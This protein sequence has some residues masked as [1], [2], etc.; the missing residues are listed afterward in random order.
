MRAKKVNDIE[1]LLSKLNKEHL[2][3]FIRRE[4]ANNRQLKQRFLALGV[5]VVFTPKYTDYQ[6]RV[7]DI[8][9][10]FAGRRGYVSYRDTF[11]L[12]RAVSKIIDEAEEA[13][14]NHRWEV[15][16]AVL[17]GV[18]AASEDIISCGDDSA[19]ELGCIVEDCFSEWLELCREELLPAK[20]KNDIF[21]LSISYFEK[22]HLKDYDWW[23]AWIEMAILLADTPQKQERIVN[24]LDIIINTHS[25]DWNVEYNAQTAQRYK[26]EVM[27]RSG[28]PEE[29]LRF[30]YDNVNNPDFRQKLLQLSWDKGDYEEVLRLAEEGV[31]HDSQFIGL[32]ND[33][34]KWE[35]KTYRHKND[36]ANILKL[37]Q[38]F[39][40]VRGG[41][42]EH[43]YSM[44]AMYALMKSNIP[45]ENWRNFVDSLIKEA[46]EKGIEVEEL[47]IYTQEKMWD[48]YMDFLRQRP[49]T[50]RLDDAPQEVWTLYKDELI[51][52]YAS[53]VKYYFQQ[54]SGRNAYCNGVALLRRLIEYGG[55]EEVDVIVDELKAL[56]PR[57]P[58]LLD[59][60]SKL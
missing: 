5:E 6:S 9:E 60:L 31:K 54:A 42:G 59:E 20:V 21:E 47:F 39:F 49:S 30:M 44:E 22:G 25:D 55:K 37:A 16:I 10:D 28:T 40:F 38:Y 17:E 32:V 26:L 24:L 35:F 41:F 50:Y 23:W 48:R 33:W 12:N 43:E 51:Q 18:A 11:A 57:R 19:G 34:R 2:C 45:N 56:K 46:S 3:E 15:A 36:K 58:A 53:C 7:E 14:S 13:I 52:L 8:I 1:L 4:C 29:Q 27:S